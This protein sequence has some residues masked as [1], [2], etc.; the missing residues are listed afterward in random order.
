VLKPQRRLIVAVCVSAIAVAAITAAGH[1]AFE[2]RWAA[3][4]RVIDQLDLGRF[5]LVSHREHNDFFSG[6]IAPNTTLDL[7][8]HSGEPIKQ[9]RAAV[10]RRMQQLGYT[11]DP[12]T[13]D[14]DYVQW[15][16][17]PP[18]GQ[19]AAH[20]SLVAVS[21]PRVGSQVGSDTNGPH[22]ITRPT[23]RFEAFSG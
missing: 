7:R 21:I 20:G 16:H 5:G 2:A 13:P 9:L 22:Q 6:D 4:D 19:D 3:T 23:I 18:A 10:T 8:P 12:F 17:S 11:S 1:A 14:A 15:Q